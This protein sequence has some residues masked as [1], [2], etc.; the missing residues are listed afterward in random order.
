MEPFEQGR[1]LVQADP[2]EFEP[3]YGPNK[4]DFDDER[5]E[6]QFPLDVVEALEVGCCSTI[7]SDR[8][9]RSKSVF[10][11]ERPRHL[12][13][14]AAETQ[15]ALPRSL[16]RQFNDLSNEWRRVIAETSGTLLLR[17]AGGDLTAARV[18]QGMLGSVIMVDRG[19]S[20]RGPH[21]GREGPAAGSSGGSYDLRGSSSL[22]ASVRIVATAQFRCHLWSA[23][24]TYQGATSV[25]VA[26]SISS[27]AAW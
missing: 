11:H 4:I 8:S 22:S 16:R 24:M 9:W 1:G 3:L 21:S 10:R 26:S 12:P 7:R 18:A 6:D 27:N 2:E 15:L 23:G 5:G 13:H 14:P 17:G 20:C 19:C 25:D